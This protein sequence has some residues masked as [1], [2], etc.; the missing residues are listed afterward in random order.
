MD[1]DDLLRTIEW[2]LP[3]G[4]FRE[5]I[6]H[7]YINLSVTRYCPKDGQYGTSCRTPS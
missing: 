2:K 5:P 1:R 3:G 6:H 4:D 7:R